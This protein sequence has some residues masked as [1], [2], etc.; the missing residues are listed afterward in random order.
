[1]AKKRK[2]PVALSPR[3]WRADENKVHESLISVVQRLVSNDT[4]RP[5]LELCRQAYVDE[6]ISETVRTETGFYR[7]DMRTRWP[8]L[9]SGV[10]ATH[11]KL[12]PVHVRPEVL[13]IDGDWDL[14]NA[15]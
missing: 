1:V 5:W 4:R 7:A 15:A 10:D 13:T 3:W 6:P 9:R 14:S 2:K 8:A 12:A 11:A